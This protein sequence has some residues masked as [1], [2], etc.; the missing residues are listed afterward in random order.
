MSHA[1]R[2][3]A[4][5]GSLIPPHLMPRVQVGSTYSRIRIPAAACAGGVVVVTGTA[6]RD[7]TGQAI[8]IATGET[9]GHAS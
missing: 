2:R 6:G 4:F 8:A 3:S 7:R 5:P 1:T 9:E